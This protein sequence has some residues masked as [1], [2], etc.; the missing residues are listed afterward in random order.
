MSEYSK[1]AQELAYAW[2][3]VGY[4]LEGIATMFIKMRKEID[5]LKKVLELECRWLQ[6]LQ[7]LE[8]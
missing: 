7:V 4:P 5:I 2:E 3:T 1:E 6:R 8:D